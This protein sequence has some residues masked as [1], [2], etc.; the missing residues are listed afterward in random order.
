MLGIKVGSQTIAQTANA[1]GIGHKFVG[2]KDDDFIFYTAAVA[3]EKPGISVDVHLS[4][5]I[6][7]GVGMLQGMGDLSLI[8]TGGASKQAK[9]NVVWFQGKFGMIEA[10]FGYQMVSVGGLENDATSDDD[11]ADM[12]LKQWLQEESHSLMNFVVKAKLGDFTPFLA[13]QSVDGKAVS[14]TDLSALGTA[15]DMIDSYGLSAMGVKKYNNTLAD[16]QKKQLS[17]IGIGVIGEIGPGKL[18]ADYVM[19]STPEWGTEGYVAAALEMGSAMHVNYGLSLADSSTLTVF[20]NSYTAK[21]DSKL[22]EDIDTMKNNAELFA[23]FA[24]A[25]NSDLLKIYTHTSTSSIG[26]SFQM[27]FGN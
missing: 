8:V 7:L 4:K 12:I 18:A 24:A 17:T 27:K 21:E 19:I 3:D 26:V 2:D 16:T 25:D 15:N 1:Y 23:P 22:R 11:A 13:Y 9:N 10:I 6:E 14:N 5:D 20:Y